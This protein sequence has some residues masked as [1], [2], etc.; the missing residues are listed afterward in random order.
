MAIYGTLKNAMVLPWYLNGTPG[1][2]Q[3]YCDKPYISSVS[4]YK[5][6]TFYTV[7]S[8]PPK[9]TNHAGLKKDIFVSNFPAEVLFIYL[10][11]CLEGRG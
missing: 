1:Y 5:H 8:C 4:W 10:L 9:N 11:I 2:F 3:D 6:I 7:F